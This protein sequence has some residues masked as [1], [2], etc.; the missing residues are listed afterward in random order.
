MGDKEQ[1]RRSGGSWSRRATCCLCWSGRCPMRA[2][3][4][5]WRRDSLWLEPQVLCRPMYGACMHPMLRCYV[6]S[7]LVGSPACFPTM[8]RR[9]PSL[10]RYDAYVDPRQ[11]YIHVMVATLAEA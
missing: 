9:C 2:A 10:S 1:E 11:Q 4:E 8:S 3:E 7:S 5:A 6:M